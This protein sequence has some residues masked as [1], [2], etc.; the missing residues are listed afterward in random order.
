M[1]YEPCDYFEVTFPVIGILVHGRS[2][3]A[4]AE[5]VS[6]DIVKLL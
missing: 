2:Y 1:R 5:V 4:V 3:L 6:Q